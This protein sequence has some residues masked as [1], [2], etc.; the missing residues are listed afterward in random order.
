MVWVW[1]WVS[2]R[3]LPGVPSGG[4]VLG[5]FSGQLSLG[6]VE[7]LRYSVVTI[8]VPLSFAA[9]ISGIGQLPNALERGLWTHCT[10]RLS[11]SPSIEAR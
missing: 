2:A 3:S 7:R 9:V 10:I 8:L 1:E 4:R 5:P 11:S 6:C